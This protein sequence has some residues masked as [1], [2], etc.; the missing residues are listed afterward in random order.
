MD[1]CKVRGPSRVTPRTH[2][3]FWGSKSDSSRLT[4]MLNL[5]FLWDLW[6]KKHRLIEPLLHHYSLGIK[7]YY[8]SN[9]VY[10]LLVVHVYLYLG[11]EH[12]PDRHWH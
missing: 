5:S 8:L 7:V 11:H 2:R 6:P 10:M 9:L 1:G 4:K 12:E 3:L